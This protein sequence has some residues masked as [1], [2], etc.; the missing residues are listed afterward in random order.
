M[1]SHFNFDD[2]FSCFRW[3]HCGIGHQKYCLDHAITLLLL[4][5]G[6]L[7]AYL[8]RWWIS[9]LCFLVTLRLMN[10][11]R[12]SGVNIYMSFCWCFITDKQ[13]VHANALMMVSDM[14][15]WS[16]ILFPVVDRSS[17]FSE[18][19]EHKTLH[20]PCHASLSKILD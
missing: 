16:K 12:F 2:W 13:N 14:V 18:G 4:M 17:S 11:S 5:C 20:F 10:F 9:A 1:L 19:D 8:L 6:Q 15:S 3:W 7:V